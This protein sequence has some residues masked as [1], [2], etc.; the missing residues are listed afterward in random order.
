MSKTNKILKG[1]AGLIL[2][3]VLMLSACTANDQDNPGQRVSK[4][5]GIKDEDRV[6]LNFTYWGSQDEKLAI[7]YA[8]KKF[9]DKN[10]DIA[11]N[12]IQIP[13][14]QYNQKMVSLAAGNDS[15]DIGYM[16][17]DLGEAW[18]NEGRFVNFLPLLEKDSEYKKEDFLDNIW[19]Q[20]SPENVWGIS[21]AAECFGLYYNKELLKA[22]GIDSLP[23]KAEDAMDWDS[24]VRLAKKLTLDSKGRNAENP[25]FDAANIRQYGVMFETWEEPINNMIF[26]NG[27]EWISPDGKRFTLNSTESSEAIQKLA[28]LINKHHVAPSPFAAKSLPSMNVALQAKLTAMAIGGQWMNL[29]LGNAKVN[30]DIGVLPKLKKSVTVGLS[31][32]TVLFKSSKHPEEAWKFF[33]WLSNPESS[34]ELYSSGLWMPT[35][36]KWYTDTN[37]VAKWVDANPS[38]HPAG[39]KDAMMNQLLRNGVPQPLYYMKNS[40]KIVPV[41]VSELDPVWMG[42]KTA[43]EALRVI[44][45]KVRPEFKGRYDVR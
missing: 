24:F 36:K 12:P 20:L 10:P 22:A 2:F 19:Y 9:M 38:A 29:D 14:A 34:I 7:E 1:F 35:M 26:S 28:D 25:E 15:P 23:S 13:N 45:E 8:C 41:V 30:Y 11:I 39:F 17:G 3:L 18:A 43:A 31:G 44:E 6:K 4:A 21:T 32:A 42:K 37:L 40:S 27:G 33:K 5:N 16:T